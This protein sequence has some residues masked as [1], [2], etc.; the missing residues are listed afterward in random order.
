MINESL[1]GLSLRAY[2]ED[3]DEEVKRIERWGVI[4]SCLGYAMDHKEYII[5]HGRKEHPQFSFDQVS[6]RQKRQVYAAPVLI[7]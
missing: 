3:E 6:F 5:F 7:R 4:L 1:D 2:S